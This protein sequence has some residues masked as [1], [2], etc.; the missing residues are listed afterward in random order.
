MSLQNSAV[1][2][3]SPAQ[4]KIPVAE[5]PSG[6]FH[7]T[8]WGDYFLKYVSDSNP[9]S[10]HGL[11]EERIERLK[12]EVR[13]MLTGAL[14]KPSQK[15][16]LIDQVQRMGIAYHFELEI[17]DQLEQIHRNYF[18][19]H[20]G[21]NEDDLHTVALLFRLFRQ[22]GYNVPC[23]IFNRFKDSEGNFSKSII[24]D[25][26]GLLSLYEACHLSYHGEDMLD[27]ALAF[28]RTHLESIDKIKASP[29]L[30]KLV[31]HALH[32]PIHK[33]LPRLETRRYIEFYQEDPSHNEVL[34]SLAK[35]DFNSL[36][37]QYRK[38]LGNLTRWWID[39]D[40]E[41]EF[42]FARDRLA[43]LYVWMVGVYFEPEYEIA[44]AI[45]TKMLVFLS[46]LDDIYDVYGKWEELELFTEAI[47]RWDD[48]AKEGLPK[49]MQVF[50]KALLDFSDEIGHEVTRR[51][52][53]YRLFYFKEAMNIQVRTY[54]AEAKWFHQSHVPTMEEYLPIALNT[55]GCDLTYVTSFLGMGDVVTKD[56]FEWVYRYPNIVNGGRAVGRIMND[57]AGHK[58]EQER[59]HVASSVECF[60]KQHGATE[61]EAN[62]ELCKLVVDAWKDMNEGLRHPTVI[63][64]AVLMRVIN[65]ARATHAVYEDKTDHYVNAGTNFKEFV[66]C[67]LV[68]P[69][70]M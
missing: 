67:L 6:I 1:L 50:H 55:I 14:D 2:S 19:L 42:P 45:V 54:L 64:M 26:Q 18:E 61:E 28:T 22:Q 62:E 15:L 31:S 36:Q 43:E 52:K 65:L 40:I 9:M 49:R 46:I 20:H 16:N 69:L 70:P 51:G 33:G 59:G 58:F 10:S 17:D 3:S 41:G 32:Q 66:T 13:K 7:T 57:V 11:A 38:E 47:Q 4:P 30:E 68:N 44:R 37:K 48:D 35:H 56:A 53:S 8:I 23:E 34:L 5:R 60:M 27:E 12:G 24:A 39:L 29:S 25:V 21:D 63:P